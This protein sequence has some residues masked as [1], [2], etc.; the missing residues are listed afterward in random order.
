M[1]LPPFFLF[2]LLLVCRK[3]THSSTGGRT[4]QVLVQVWVRAITLSEPPSA[5]KVKAQRLQEI[6]L[7]VLPLS[8]TGAPQPTSSSYSRT[9]RVCA[10]KDSLAEDWVD[11]K[12]KR[13]MIS[14]GMARLAPRHFLHLAKSLA[15]QYKCLREDTYACVR[16]FLPECHAGPPQPAPACKSSSSRS[17][18]PLF[19]TK[20]FLP[21][22]HHIALFM[23]FFFLFL[24][25][26]FLFVLPRPRSGVGLCSQRVFD[27]WA[28]RTASKSQVLARN[29]TVAL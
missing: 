5:H 29:C 15:A 11:S 8:G 19:L 28:A 26:F 14:S 4:V 18:K 21:I 9:P 20:T 13:I 7:T 24:S 16:S 3:G 25:F 12:N 22:Q 17:L 27:A 23:C 10:T 6:R 2:C 1:L